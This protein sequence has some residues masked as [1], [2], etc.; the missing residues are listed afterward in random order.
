MTKD[1][2]DFEVVVGNPARVMP[3]RKHIEPVEEDQCPHC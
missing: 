3:P 1:V 2:G